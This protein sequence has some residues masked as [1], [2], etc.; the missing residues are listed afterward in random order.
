MRYGDIGYKY[1]IFVNGEQVF[2]KTN[3]HPQIFENVKVYAGSPHHP[4]V[5]G[6]IKELKVNGKSDQG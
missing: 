2:S 3:R 1:K 6:K 4:T 5:T